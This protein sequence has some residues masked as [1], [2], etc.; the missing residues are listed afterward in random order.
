[1]SHYF[2]YLLTHQP[3]QFRDLTYFDWVH[4]RVS[5]YRSRTW[6]ACRETH[7]KTMILPD[8][9][10]RKDW[11]TY[12]DLYKRKFSF[13]ID[14][15]SSVEGELDRACGDQ[16]ITQSLSIVHIGYKV[17]APHLLGILNADNIHR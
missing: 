13:S 2:W 8:A 3:D 10:G 6:H 5:N 14:A 9:D 11:T 4:A 15:S 1:M 16:P 7:F 12:A 17:R